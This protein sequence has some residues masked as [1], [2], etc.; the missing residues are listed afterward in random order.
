[1]RTRHILFAL[2]IPFLCFGQKNNYKAKAPDWVVPIAVVD[3]S[4]LADIGG[5][6]YLLVDY[7][8][9]LIEETEFYHYVIRIANSEG[10]SDH[11]DL[12]FSYDPTYQKLFVHQLDIT[13]KE[14][15]INK[16]STA[17]IKTI[18]NEKSMDRSIYD[19]SLTAI[20]H[21]DDVR[22]DDII[23]YSYSIK[24][25][26]PINEG[27]YSSRFYQ[28]FT[29]PVNRLWQSLICSK[30]N[31]LN[32]S[33][34][35]DAKPAMKEAEGDN[36][37]YSWDLTAYEFITYENNTPN[38]YNKQKTAYYSTYKDWSEVVEWAE[39]IYKY[40]PNIGNALLE[41]FDLELPKEELIQKVIQFVS[42]EVRYLGLESGISAYK[43]HNPLAVY[44]QK[45]G[46][47]K[48]KSLL[49]TAMLRAL[50]IDAYPVLVNTKTK[51]EVFSRL[52]AHNI[53]NH[54]VVNYFYNGNSIFIDPTIQSDA[55]IGEI[56]FPNYG[57]GLFIRK[58]EDGL[59]QLP[60]SQKRGR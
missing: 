56:P 39:T 55:D 30:N 3:D 29:L 31:Q 58:N 42:N 47:C 33:Y 34:K 49:L 2:L 44:H 21:L 14:Q 7:Q 8:D 37:I 23:E 51:H 53:F 6:Q 26:N 35:N 25:F 50:K 16:L 32:F 59:T 38:W 13:R 27:H 43:P 40:D 46:D 45:Y 22:V 28:Q 48:D 41:S 5:S 36:I 19:G 12:D 9:N 1:M 60:F 54:C 4:T 15:V 52:P 11:A 10:I 57:Y 20:V 18:Q 24:G 17:K